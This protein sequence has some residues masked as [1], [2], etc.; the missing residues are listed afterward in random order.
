MAMTFNPND[1]QP[2]AIE[3]A[4]YIPNRKPKF[5]THKGKGQALNAFT[6]RSNAILYKYNFDKGEW[7]EIYRVEDKQKPETCAHC[8]K[9]TMEDSPYKP[10]NR[11][12][13][14]Q[15]IWE[16]VR[17]G[18][19]TADPPRQIYV[20]RDCET[21]LVRGQKASDRQKAY[22]IETARKR[23]ERDIGQ[24]SLTDM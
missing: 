16:R 5:K 3:W 17:P 11:S 20:C 4:T 24:L 13:R 2:K 8:S 6:Y 18:G 15:F 21:L 1:K 10:Y 12:N 23:R 19:K 7:I 9:S 22:Q 14:G